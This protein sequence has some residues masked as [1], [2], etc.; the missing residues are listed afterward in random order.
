M[1][2]NFPWNWHGYAAAPVDQK[3][4]KSRFHICKYS[5]QF[6]KIGSKVRSVIVNKLIK[7][8]EC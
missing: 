6:I 4:T 8:D 7:D 2:I 1:L 5:E 3:Q